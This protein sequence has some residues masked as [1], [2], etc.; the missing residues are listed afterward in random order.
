MG[1]AS[2]CRTTSLQ[3]FLGSL[4]IQAVSPSLFRLKHQADGSGGFMT[5]ALSGISPLGPFV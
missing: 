2:D 3:A 1:R 5:T 4:L